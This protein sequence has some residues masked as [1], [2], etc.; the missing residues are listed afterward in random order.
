MS[1]VV[2]AAERQGARLLIQLSGVSGSGKT[3]TALMLAYGL[4]GGDGSKI[5]GIDTENR[6]MSLNA[7]CLPDGAKFN[8]IDFYA[9]FTPG[10]YIEAIDAAIAGGAE[11]IVIDSVSHEWEGPGGCQDIANASRFPDWKKAKAEHKRLMTH[12]LQCPAHIIA[13][14]RAREK[15]DFTDTK[16]P[17]K[18]GLQPIQEQNFSYEATVSLMMHNQ[19]MHQ[20]VLKCPAELQDIMGRGAGYISPADGEALRAWVDGG[21]K[22]DH[23][24]E[25]ARG[26]LRNVAEKGLEAFKAA[27]NALTPKQR[28]SLGTT[29]R[30]EVAAS[31]KAYDDNQKL[32][33]PEVAAGV[34]ALN[35]VAAAATAPAAKQEPDDEQF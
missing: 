27:W 29:F 21:A 13:C 30:D 33:A 25:Q 23:A 35:A 6:R 17:V 4:T 15:V 26:N 22:V 18:L 31:A 19:G 5:V 14:T 16:N 12:M 34:D 24:L 9:P 28:K 7:D 10:R 20:S 11:V 1:F 8:I 32:A 3:V 2:K